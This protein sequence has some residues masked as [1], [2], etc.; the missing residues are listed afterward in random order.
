MTVQIGFSRRPEDWQAITAFD[1]ENNL[2]FVIEQ[3]EKSRKP[4][5]IERDGKRICIWSSFKKEAKHKPYAK[6]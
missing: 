6:S 1:S 3:L 2:W 4:Y 5:A